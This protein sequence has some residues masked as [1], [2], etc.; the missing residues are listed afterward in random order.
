M[1]C[2]ALRAKGVV[3]DLAGTHNT[4]VNSPVSADAERLASATNGNIDENEALRLAIEAS[5]QDQSKVAEER[6]LEVA[7]MA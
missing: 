5:L 7:Q 2:E 6:K 3:I 4:N 1:A